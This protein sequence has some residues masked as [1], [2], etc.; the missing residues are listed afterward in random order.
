MII[1]QKVIDKVK[2]LI[3]DTDVCINYPFLNTDGYGLIQTGS[4][5]ENKKHYLA[6]RVSYQIYNNDDINS[7][8]IICHCCDNPA[9]INPKHLFK[10]THEDNVADRQ[11]KNRQAKGKENGRYKHGYNSKYNPVEKPKTPFEQLNGRKFTKEQILDLKQKINN[12]GNL[13]LKKLSEQI[14]ISYCTIRDLN[15]GRIY[16]EVFK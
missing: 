8:N 6:H 1:E 16:K 12:R 7:N 4:N 9:C 15:C 3:Q 10:G 2:L 5:K 13:S 11:N 14:N